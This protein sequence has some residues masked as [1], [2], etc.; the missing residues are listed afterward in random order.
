MLQARRS[1]RATTAWLRAAQ[2]ALA[3]LVA[4]GSL[5]L[6]P[7]TAADE[8]PEIPGIDAKEAR[9]RTNRL[10][11]RAKRWWNMRRRLAYKCPMCKGTGLVI[12]Y[13]TRP[14]RRT[15]VRCTQC[16]GRLYYVN[17]KRYRLLYFDMRTPAFRGKTGAEDSVTAAFKET[18][19]EAKEASR[20]D[21]RVDD[22]E[23]R[24]PR[25]GLVWLHS[26]GDR[27][28]KPQLWVYA[29]ELDGD[30]DW[31]LWQ[32]PAIDGPF[33]TE[34]DVAQALT[35]EKA[36]EDAANA[37]TLTPERRKK[38][39]DAL[40]ATK[41]SFKVHGV[42]LVRDSLLI[43]LIDSEGKHKQPFL[44]RA[45]H[46]CVSLLRAAWKGRDEWNH[47]TLRWNTKWRNKLGEVKHRPVAL[48]HLD[49][50]VGTRAK[51]ENLTPSEQLALVHFDNTGRHEKQGWIPWDDKIPK[52][53]PRR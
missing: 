34:Q 24:G 37:P 53:P 27:Q 18:V 14:A 25:H 42:D 51:W 45:K 3:A 35:R 36:A 16:D 44:E 11:S 52:E 22:V 38:V 49:E 41:T 19:H 43:D 15:R 47:L 31:F 40:A 6:C 2:F 30:E 32:D 28:S 12:Q 13:Q 33:P 8:K 21:R 20:D 10:K 39:L 23:L 9:I 50:K 4:A 48:A 5:W 29:P 17:P 26:D 7:P 46:E 1:S